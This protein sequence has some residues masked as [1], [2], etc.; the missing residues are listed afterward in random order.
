VTLKDVAALAGVSL[1]TASR[2]FNHQESVSPERCERVREALKKLN[3]HPHAVAKRL[4]TGR[5]NVLRLYMIQEYPILPST[6]GHYL[7]IIQGVICVT[8]AKGY[9]LELDICSIGDLEKK[10]V[11]IDG[12]GMS[13]FDGV[14]L[15]GSWPVEYWLIVEIVKNNL[16]Y[17]L[18]N[19]RVPGKTLNEIEMDNKGAIIEAVRYLHELGHSRIALISGPAGQINMAD[20]IDGYRMG[21][22][23]CGLEIRDALQRESDFTIQGGYRALQDL[24]AVTPRPSAVVCG[25]DHL[26]AGALRA[27]MD[28]GLT[29]PRDVSIM[30]FDNHE[31]AQVTY[32]ALTTIEQPC[33]ELGITA[34]ERIIALIEGNECENLRTIMPCKL[35][36]RESTGRLGV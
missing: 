24:W 18:V 34:A 7:R 14:L 5:T 10:N 6:W 32:P 27:A 8:Q 19:T 33:Q 9:S 23:Q 36:I 16:P 15:L 20:R 17:F 25:N 30:G 35:I 11:I 1:G 13:M 12:A 29:V 3:Y 4:A 22:R 2:V 26:A 31:L 21:L 28:L